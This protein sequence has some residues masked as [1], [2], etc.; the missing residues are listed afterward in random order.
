MI[1]FT[2]LTYIYN[3]KKYKKKN[4]YDN[5][6]NGAKRDKGNYSGVK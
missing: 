1:Y 2:I 5:D 4:N 6:D 3:T